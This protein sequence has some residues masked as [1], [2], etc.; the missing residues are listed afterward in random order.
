MTQVQLCIVHLVRHS[1]NYVS[2]K[3]LRVVA[4]DLRPIYTAPTAEEAAARLDEFAAKWDATY[5]T[6]QV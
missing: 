6:R 2:W 5:P 1:L 3:Q 4:A